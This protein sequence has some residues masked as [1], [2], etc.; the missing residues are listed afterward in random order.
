[1]REN[2]SA[3]IHVMTSAILETGR[4]RGSGT[5]NNYS[6][7][8]D[9]EWHQTTE[10]Q[11]VLAHLTDPQTGIRKV[12][13][14]LERP[15]IPPTLNILSY[16]L[17]LVGKTGAGKTSLVSYLSGQQGWVSSNQ[18]ETPGI[19]ATSVYWPVK[20]QSQLVL[21]HLNLWD[22]GEVASKKYSHILPVCKQDSSGALFVFSFTD[23][24]SFE[25]L[26]AQLSRYIHPNS[27][28][29][30]IVVG[31]RYGL[32]SDTQVSNTDVTNLE[33]KWN[34]SVLRIRYQSTQSRTPPNSSESALILNLIC[35]Q[36]YTQTS[37]SGR[38][39]DPVLI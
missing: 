5:G 27:P 1:M 8:L 24:S 38:P 29:C 13:G 7:S 34:V 21:F 15:N 9:L 35:D 2:L 20:I 33:S 4:G 22:Y 18:G 26:D 23:K 36:L 39:I 32:V 3:A 11:G 28:V 6:V 14:F 31:M 19:R 16:K 12:Y 30:P 25:D 17:F 10:G 37:K